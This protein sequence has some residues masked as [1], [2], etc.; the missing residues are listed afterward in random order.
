MQSILSASHLHLNALFRQNG[1][2]FLNVNEG[3]FAHKDNASFSR[4]FK[5]CFGIS[6]KKWLDSNRLKRQ[7]F[8]ADVLQKISMKFAENVD[9]PQLRS[10]LHDLKKLLEKLPNN[11]KNQKT[12]IFHQK[13][14]QLKVI[15]S[16]N[17]VFK[18]YYKGLNMKE[19]IAKAV[20][21]LGICLSALNAQEI[22]GFASPESIWVE[23]NSVYVANVGEKLA[24][25]IKDNDGFIS[26]LDTQGN[27]IEL[28][29]LSN[30]N[31]PKG[32]TQL[33]NTLFVV[34]IDTLKG[35]DILSKK[36]V[37]SL[38]IVDS[39]FLNDIAAYDNNTLFMS[40]TD[41]GIIHKVNVK[42]KKYETFIKLD[43]DK[44]GGPNGLLFD[45]DKTKLYV[46]STRGGEVLSID[47]QSLGIKTLIAQKGAYDGLAFAKNGDLLV[48]SWGENGKGV[49]YRIDKKGKKSTLNLPF[50]KGPA[51]M[52]SDGESLW[53]PKMGENKILKINLP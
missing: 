16:Y 23:G 18:F 6:P 22:S 49:I 37:F 35:F 3:G 41:T 20:C 12:Y 5:Q 29:F 19:K 44:Y 15:F 30:L 42:N 11:T 48:S 9:L 26:K 33:D 27:I 21:A 43:T 28:H 39:V 36:Q 38:P 47:M 17:A 24:P 1:L 10:L 34:D 31:A 32:M 8:Y 52:F 50:I 4:E 2:E 7:N 40:D 13:L 53:I 25:L 14:T 51:D 45:K 46:A